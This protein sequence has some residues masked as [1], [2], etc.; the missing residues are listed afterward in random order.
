MFKKR[1]R[2]KKWSHTHKTI[3]T[4]SGNFCHVVN[5]TILSI[6]GESTKRGKKTHRSVWRATRVIFQ[7]FFKRQCEKNVLHWNWPVWRKA[8][9]HLQHFKQNTHHWNTQHDYN[10]RLLCTIVK[11]C[12]TLT[13]LF[14]TA[15]DAPWNLGKTLTTVHW[16]SF[17][18]SD[19]HYIQWNQHENLQNGFAPYKAQVSQ[20]IAAL[21]SFLSHT[22]NCSTV[23]KKVE[24]LMLPLPRPQNGDCM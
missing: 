2:R 21:R 20:E 7:R 1:T 6:L 10:E 12:N 22:E 19:V 15:L 5:E 18:T 11:Q 8:E 16:M 24:M 13:A 4:R 14:R 9:Q 17:H 3:G 23:H